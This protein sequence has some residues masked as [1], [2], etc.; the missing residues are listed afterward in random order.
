[1]KKLV[2]TMALLLAATSVSA[3]SL[4]RDGTFNGGS[5][6][7]TAGQ[8]GTMDYWPSTPNGQVLGWYAASTHSGSTISVEAT[9]GRCYCTNNN[10]TDK[11]AKITVNWKSGASYHIIFRTLSYVG[12]KGK[13][14]YNPFE[15]TSGST[16][17]Y[18]FW[19]KTDA[20]GYPANK[21]FP[22]INKNVMG[23]TAKNI[24]NSINGNTALTTEWKQYIF[25]V[26]NSP[27]P[28]D[29]YPALLFTFQAAGT[30]YI[31]DVEISTVQPTA[32]ACVA[33][34]STG[35]DKAVAGN[36][37]LSIIGAD[38]GITFSSIGGHV[39]VYDITGKPAAQKEVT[40]GV[41][42]I[43]LPAGLYIVKLN[44]IAVKAI[45]K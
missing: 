8:L 10:S 24:T 20:N 9:E 36:A 44:G 2:Y 37:P 40:A 19:A 1:M 27:A 38:G 21:L 13:G 23:Y 4:W 39:S 7:Y 16:F 31:D 41:S 5:G 28:S 26:T 18:S 6:T 33:C 29:T 17:Y 3:Q 30:V 11:A 43:A 32:T 14:D 45:V 22:T 12:E 15:V 35:I 42:H 25:E 34:T